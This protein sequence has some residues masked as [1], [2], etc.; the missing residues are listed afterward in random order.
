MRIMGL[1]DSVHWF[2]WFILCTSVMLFTAVLLVVVIKVN[3]Q[4]YSELIENS[5]SYIFFLFSLVKSLN[6]RVFQFY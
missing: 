2:T 1:N 5:I 6:I 3:H 4:K